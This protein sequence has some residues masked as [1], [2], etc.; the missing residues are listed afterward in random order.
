MKPLKTLWKKV[1]S[2]SKFM[3]KAIKCIEINITY[4]E[5][6]IKL[7]PNREDRDRLNAAVELI[8]HGNEYLAQAMRHT[9]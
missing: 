1:D 5:D 3:L 2:P 6:K 9:K 8:K 4:L 7:S